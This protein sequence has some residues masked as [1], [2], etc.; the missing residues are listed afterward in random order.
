MCTLRRVLLM[1]L[2]VLIAGSWSHAQTKKYDLKSGIL[3]FQSTTFFGTMKME[4]KAIVY[5]DDYGMKECKESFE[6][7]ELKESFFSDGK[8]LFTLVHKKKEAYDR[9]PASRG[10]ELKF[11]WNEV[12]KNTNKDYKVQ[13]L[14]P[15]TIAGKPCESFSIES[16]QG[17]NIFAGY[18][19]VTFLTHVENKQMTTDLR[20]VK[21]EENVAVPADKFKVPAGYAVKK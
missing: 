5:F 14:A 2:A 6:D 20:A 3:T 10:T 18:K 8:T 17:K 1:S 21:F 9:G 19:G 7:D 4:S 16:K 13:K 12:S 15:V 11:D